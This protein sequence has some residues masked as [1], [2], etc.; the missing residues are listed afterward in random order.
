MPFTTA[1]IAGRIDNG[2]STLVDIAGTTLEEKGVTPP[3]IDGGGENDTT[4]MRNVTWRTRAPMSLKTLTEASFRAAYAV[5]AYTTLVNA[6]NVNQL[7][8]I[9]FPDGSELAF[10]GWLNQFEPGEVV[11]GEQPEADVTIIASNQ[12]ASGAEV[13]P[14]YTPPS[15]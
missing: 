8:T 14:V 15:S 4:T 13:A 11:E 1:R 7:I 10:W 12:N 9:R 6:I 5:A 2:F 3:G